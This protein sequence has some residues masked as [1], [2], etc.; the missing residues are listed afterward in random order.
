MICES[1][2]IGVRLIKAQRRLGM[3]NI[4]VAERA[5]VK[6]SNYSRFLYGHNIPSVPTLIALAK[7][8]HTSVD[9]LCSLTDDPRPRKNKSSTV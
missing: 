7:A 3:R 8:L 4:A 2:S 6:P 5:D 9:Y 1:D